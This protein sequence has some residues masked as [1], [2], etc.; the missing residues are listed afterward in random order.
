MKKHPWKILAGI[1]TALLSSLYGINVYIGQDDA[2][3][4]EQISD[5]ST[6]SETVIRFGETYDLQ[7]GYKI[8]ISI[9]E[10]GR[11]MVIFTPGEKK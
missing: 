11:K 5:V 10:F 2:P 4:H 7:D 9:D 3:I 8:Q 6:G 1:V